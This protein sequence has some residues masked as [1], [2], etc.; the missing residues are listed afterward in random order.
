MSVVNMIPIVFYSLL[1]FKVSKFNFFLY[2]I[3]WVHYSRITKKILYYQRE[4]RVWIPPPQPV[5]ITLPRSVQLL[6]WCWVLLSLVSGM[7][8]SPCKALSGASS[9][10]Q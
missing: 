8:G 9:A 6:G 1:L 4:S 3:L 2:K 10:P 7:K 5:P